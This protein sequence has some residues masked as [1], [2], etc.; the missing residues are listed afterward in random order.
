M[1]DW[2]AKTSQCFSNKTIHYSS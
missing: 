1:L 2:T